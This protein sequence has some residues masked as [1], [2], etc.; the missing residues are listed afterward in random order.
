M[1]G[2]V[3]LFFLMLYGFLTLLLITVCCY[4][5]PAL[6][7]FD[8]PAGWIVKLSFLSAGTASSGFG[9]APDDICGGICVGFLEDNAG[10]HCAGN[11]GA[12]YFLSG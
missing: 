1:D 9:A 12:V 3:R 10:A 11:S 7:T 2:L 8:M 6:S 4:A 5:F